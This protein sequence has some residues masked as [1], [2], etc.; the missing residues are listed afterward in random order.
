[1]S[2]AADKETDDW[3]VTGKN[4]VDVFDRFDR[5]ARRVWRMQQQAETENYISIHRTERRAQKKAVKRDTNETTV[6]MSRILT[7]T[8]HSLMLSVMPALVCG[9]GRNT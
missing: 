7:E 3:L 8:N 9:N 2:G 4:L 5:A 6:K 1:M